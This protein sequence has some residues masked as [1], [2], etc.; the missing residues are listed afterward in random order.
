MQFDVKAMALSGALFWG[1]LAMF[2]TGLA[3]L[4]FSGYGQ[5]FLDLMATIYPGYNA[6]PSFGQVIGTSSS[7]DG[8]ASKEGSPRRWTSPSTSHSSS[9]GTWRAV[10]PSFFFRL[11]AM[12]SR[13]E[14]K[15]MTAKKI[16]PL[17]M[18]SE[19]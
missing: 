3:N 15:M 5:G 18:S 8:S 14:K 12:A 16:R 9:G 11:R 2:L 6:T 13:I 4:I 17:S 19:R 7:N 1:V 10:A